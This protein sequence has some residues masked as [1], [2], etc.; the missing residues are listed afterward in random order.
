MNNDQVL[1]PPDPSTAKGV[2]VESVSPITA[3]ELY[4]VIIES[5]KEDN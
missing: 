5:I 2:I 4:L 3:L 1:P